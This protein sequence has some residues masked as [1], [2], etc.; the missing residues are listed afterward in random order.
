GRGP[1]QDC[2]TDADRTFHSEATA[3]SICPQGPQRGGVNMAAIP[4]NIPPVTTGPTTSQGGA[5]G[6]A[7]A[8]R[9]PGKQA[10][11]LLALTAFVLVLVPVCALVVPPGHALHLSDYALT[12][13]GKILC[14]GV[15]A[16]ALGLVWGYS[17]I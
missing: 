13:T 1:G 2:R 14:Y 16:L 6:A 12:L 4:L 10:L 8:G 11:A 9:S 17:G 3:G 15:G 5:G 7:P